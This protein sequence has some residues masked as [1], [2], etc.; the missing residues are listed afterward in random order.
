MG[1]MKEIPGE[2]LAEKT[3]YLTVAGC[4]VFILGSVL[5]VLSH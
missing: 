3:F 2:D 1:I 5:F 4:L